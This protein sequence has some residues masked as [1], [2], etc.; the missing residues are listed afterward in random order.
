MKMR[1]KILGILAIM[2]LGCADASGQAL[3]PEELPFGKPAVFLRQKSNK[4]WCIQLWNESTDGAVFLVSY[5]NGSTWINLPLLRLARGGNRGINITDLDVLGSRTYVSGNFTFP[6]TVRNCLAYFDQLSGNWK[7]DLEFTLQPPGNGAVPVVQTLFTHNN[8]L[9]AGGLFSKVGTTECQNLLK[10]ELKGFI[11]RPVRNGN[12]NGAFGMVNQITADSNGKRL[13]LAG[14]F[15]RILGQG[16]SGLA[17]FNPAD[18][19]ASG[20]G[21]SFNNVIRIGVSGSHLVL[22]NEEDTSRYR[23]IYESFAGQWSVPSNVDSVFNIS[24]IMVLSTE[25][26]LTGTIRTGGVRRTGLFRLSAKNATIQLEKFQRIEF[27]ELFGGEL[28][29]AGPF[30][31]AFTLSQESFTVARLATDMFRVFGRVFHD[32]NANGKFDAGELRLAG[33]LIR[34]SPTGQFIPTDRN[35]IFTFAGFAKSSALYLLALNGLPGEFNAPVTR[36]IK[37]DSVPD[38]IIDFPMQFSRTNYRDFRI[39]MASAAGNLARPDNAEY[40]FLTVENTGTTAGATNL[41]L[42]YNNKLVKVSPSLGPNQID[43]GRL[44]WNN[45]SLTPGEEKSILVKITAPSA[46]F[47]NSE[48]FGLSA[49]ISGSADD[50]NGNDKDTLTQTVASAV[51]PMAKFQVPAPAIQ[52]DSIGWYDPASGRIDY[53]IRFTNTGTDTLDYVVVRDTVSTPSWV[54]YIQETGN[55]HP[56]SRN[57]YTNPSMPNRVI[58]VYTFSNLRLPPNPSGNPEMVTSSGFISFRLGI[59]SG[60]PAGSTIRNRAV[61]YMEDQP[62]ALTNTV[63]AK[64][65]MSNIA[66]LN[67]NQ[68]E[69]NIYPNPGTGKFIIEGAQTGDRV[70]FYGSDGRLL[71]NMPYLTEGAVSTGLPGGTYICSVFRQG[72]LIGKTIYVHL[73]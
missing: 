10:I 73:P 65:A 16:I 38:Q 34:V 11:L 62:A 12:N 48:S 52:G 55:S 71:L 1:R 21:K 57:V 2:T 30:F 67:R 42:N 32:K 33:R 18:S 23:K 56:F 5:K 7:A 19:T 39:T 43:P 61:V 4:L 58:L 6:G 66:G 37:G 63:V 50:N 68:K 14:N 45:I 26:F 13:Y 9:F 49:S 69:L 64:T 51:S 27:G 40:Y 41:V 28:F 36:R 60:I 72:S 53:T 25:S 24:N 54:T 15:K 17:L 44:T 31:N 3:V 35:G 47:M 46:A 22:V 8:T 59:S 70:I 20:A 29:L